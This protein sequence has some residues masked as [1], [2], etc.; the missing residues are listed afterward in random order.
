MHI[1]LFCCIRQEGRPCTSVSHW[2]HTDLLIFIFR[3]GIGYHIFASSTG[4]GG[5]A[6]ADSFIH[7]CVTR[8]VGFSRIY[9]TLR[10]LACSAHGCWQHLT[11]HDRLHIPRNQ[12][13]FSFFFVLSGQSQYFSHLSEKRP[14]WPWAGWHSHSVRTDGWP[15]SWKGKRRADTRF[16]FSLPSPF[17]P[18]FVSFLSGQSMGKQTRHFGGPAM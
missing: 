14:L 12:F 15:L 9:T 16:V 17:F 13:P 1:L 7:P 4:H 8:P 3:I 11:E 5:W 2:E 18:L 6:F 10:L